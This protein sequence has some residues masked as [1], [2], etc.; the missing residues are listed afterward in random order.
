MKILIIGAGEVGSYLSQLLSEEGHAVTTIEESEVKAK[1]LEE[2]Q[3]V[4][5]ITA[6]GSTPEALIE[7]EAQSCDLFLAMTDSDTTNF[8]CCSVAKALGAQKT[9]CR[10]HNEVYTGM[11]LLNYQFHFG[12]DYALNPEALCAVELVKSIRNPESVVVEDFA[13]GRI[14]V[15]QIT[16]SPQSKLI[17]RPLRDIRLDPQVRVGYVQKKE[18][19]FVAGPETVFCAGD[20]VTLVGT[21]EF[22]LKVREE[23]VPESVLKTVRVVLYGGNEVATSMVPLLSNPRFKV[24]IIEE[25]KR[26]CRALAERFPHVTIVR[27]SATSLRL[28]EEEQIGSC[29]YFVAC[30]KDDEKNIMTAL[31]AVK[32]GA[33]HTQVVINKP[34]YQGLLGNLQD[35]LKFQSLVSV[36]RATG[37]EVL[38]HSA[39]GA[40]TELATLPGNMAKIIELKVAPGSP[41]IQRKIEEIPFP[42]D[43][44]I[45]VLQHQ[46]QSKM[47]TAKD[48]IYPGDHLVIIVQEK[49]LKDVKK[50]LT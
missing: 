28:L 2:V 46:C 33:K 27:G 49:Q 21:S 14:E 19:L 31:Q 25:G 13:E 12:I 5:V 44:V 47:P 20:L 11:S 41:C 4:R 38:R 6:D 23:L 37:E 48:V 22:L 30:T 7:G 18:G 36:R 15:Q 16:V 42:R 8:V 32:L 43:A 34:D 10:V 50:L 29:D 9:I 35:I 45:V 3:N 17:G 39:T 24:R 1:E 40:I 26:T